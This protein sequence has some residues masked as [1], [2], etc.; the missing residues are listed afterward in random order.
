ML[1]YVALQELV[2]AI[3]VTTASLQAGIRPEE[4]LISFQADAPG[5]LSWSYVNEHRSPNMPS[6]DYFAHDVMD[7]YLSRI[8]TLQATKF[9]ECVL[10]DAQTF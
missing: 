2:Q 8:C 10:H 6:H 5:I 7:I 9:Q 1:N 4:A 3:I